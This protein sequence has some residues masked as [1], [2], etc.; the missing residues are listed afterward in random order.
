[1]T[2][3]GFGIFLLGTAASGTR[4]SVRPI[5]STARV[6]WRRS[7][8]SD[9]GDAAGRG[10]LVKIDGSWGIGDGEAALDLRLILDNSD[11]GLFDVICKFDYFW[12]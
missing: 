4:V 12:V 10:L 11:Y 5:N 3:S 9:D 8:A 2:R 6:P 7:E 1:M